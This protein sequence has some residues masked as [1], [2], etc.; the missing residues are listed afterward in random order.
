MGFLWYLTKS[1]GVVVLE[2]LGGLAAICTLPLYP[3][4]VIL[5]WVLDRKEEYEDQKS[6][7][8]DDRLEQETRERSNGPASPGADPQ[9]PQA[10]DDPLPPLLRTG[11]S[12]RDG[13]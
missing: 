10:D 13:P 2:V 4:F 9:A 6:R 11:R 1:F 12:G 7:R 8:A 5:E 3:V